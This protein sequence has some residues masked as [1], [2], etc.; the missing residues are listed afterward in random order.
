M[1]EIMRMNHVGWISVKDRLP[2]KGEWVLAWESQGFVLVDAWEGE[3]W[4]I[5]E[6]NCGSIDYWMPLPEPPKEGV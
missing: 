1:N 3:E 6:R 4:R 5:A 2:N